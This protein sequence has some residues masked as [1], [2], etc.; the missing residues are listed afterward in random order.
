M[1][2]GSLRSIWRGVYAVGLTEP[3]RR[4]RWMAAILACGTNAVLSHQ[5]AAALWGIRPSGSALIAVCVPPCTFRRCSGIRINR[6]ALPRADITRRDRIPVTAPA[7]TLIDLG[8]VLTP[9]EVEAAIN[10][11]DKLGLTD[12]ESLR[13]V[14]EARRGCPG[15]RTIRSV[16]DRR[17]FR[18]TDSELERRFLRLVRRASLPMPRTG[19]RVNGYRVDFY[20][21]ELK[22]VVETD[23]LRYHRTATQQ[24]R[25]RIRDQAHTAAG[26]G[27]LRFTHSQVV[28]DA[29]R[30]VELLRSVAERQ[31]LTVLGLSADSH[32]EFGGL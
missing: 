9:E 3:T 22:L 24:S 32:G 11:A 18:L 29:G 28:L 21:P 6:R 1:S 2:R 19:A 27:V 4:G 23:G 7:R 15:T 8:T 16:L 12:P 20:W 25:D 10:E 13:A 31:R 17:T 30:V 26:F 5:S 14:A